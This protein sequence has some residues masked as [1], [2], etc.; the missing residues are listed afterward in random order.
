MAAARRRHQPGPL[1][2][3]Y[4]RPLIPGWPCSVVAALESGGT[5]WTALLNAIRL[6]PGVDLAQVSTDQLRQVVERLTEA[7]RHSDGD[8]AIL[9]VVD[10]GYGVPRLA[11]VLADLPVED[12]GRMCSDRVMRRPAPSRE[13]FDRAHP[14]HGAE[15]VFGKPATWGDPRTA[16]V[17]DTIRYG[18][19]AAMAWD[20]LPTMATA[21]AVVFAVARVWQ[22]GTFGELWLRGSHLVLADRFPQRRACADRTGVS[23]ETPSAA[24]VADLDQPL[25]TGLQVPP[26]TARFQTGP[27]GSVIEDAR[28][29]TPRTPAR[30]P[31]LARMS[32][33]R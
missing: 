20:R 1:L 2:L 11:F 14:W 9:I 28:R 22:G 27:D 24:P 7:N 10:A 4:L 31:V 15:S 6:E 16:A 5:S 3:P 8:P 29:A 25:L 13:E 18:G 30:S 21:G 33:T 26:E 19:A 23:A 17:N 32:R 12:L